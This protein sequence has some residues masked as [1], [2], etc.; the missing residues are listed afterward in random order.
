MNESLTNQQ[1]EKVTKI[2]IIRQM[3]PQILKNA[4]EYLRE[5]MMS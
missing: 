2:E 5:Q 1:G 3:L 4:S